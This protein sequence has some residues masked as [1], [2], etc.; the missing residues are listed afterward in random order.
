MSGISEKTKKPAFI[1]LNSIDLDEV[2]EWRVV[3]SSEDY[4]VIVILRLEGS[5][6]IDIQ[7]NSRH[8]TSDG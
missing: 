7:S 3:E 1:K 4:A 6:F 2:I 8:T 5:A